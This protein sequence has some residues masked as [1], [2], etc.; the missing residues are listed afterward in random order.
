MIK[1]NAEE[2]TVTLL[3]EKIIFL[4]E[5]LKSKDMDTSL[6]QIYQCDKY[7]YKA[8]TKPVLKRHKTTK[9]KEKMSTPEKDDGL[10][11]PMM[12]LD[13]RAEALYFLPSQRKL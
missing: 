3:L 8:S 2:N 7:D 5:E 6:T 4:E 13:E 1:I 10:H 11:K 12:T 9:H